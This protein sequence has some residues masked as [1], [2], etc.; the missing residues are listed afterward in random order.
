MVHLDT[1]QYVSP[2]P[3]GGWGPVTHA[4]RLAAELFGA[5]F[6][7]FHPQTQYNRVWRAVSLLPRP[8]R[9]GV[10]L[11]ILSNPGD[12]LALRP[13]S[14]RSRRYS[15]EAA[16]IF[17][18]FWDE[19]IPRYARSTTGFDRLFVT[20]AELVP[21]YEEATGVPTTWLPWGTDTRAAPFVAGDRRTDVLR[22][23]RQPAP[24]TDDDV[25]RRAFSEIRV[26]FEG[27][28]R[29][30]STDAESRRYLLDAMAQSKMVMA[31]S[32]AVS[33][34]PYTHPTR[35]YISGRWT[36]A[37]A[38]GAQVLGIPPQ[39]AA[40]KL[41]PEEALVIPD[42]V[43]EADV[44]DAAAAAALSWT[45]EKAA[46]LRDHAMKVLD[47]RHRFHE[48]RTA[49]GLCAPRLDEALNDLGDARTSR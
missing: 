26:R 8:R 39:C 23:G 49:L 34:A 24:W 29:F 36:D 32:N 6:E 21:L 10:R 40:L 41:L 37:V 27:R 12:L 7:S 22:V 13:P 11:S 14:L 5:D 20:D 3:D 16:W 9:R 1:V 44:V 4:A 45:S 25:S 30:G 28:P 19:R 47:W 35:E 43:R 2:S 38:C 18:A 46:R 17:D 31:W 48:V 15:T 33:P 42:S